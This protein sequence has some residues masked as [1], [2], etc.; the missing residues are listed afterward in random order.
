MIDDA[1]VV[2][3]LSPS[4]SPEAPPTVEPLPG[5]EGGPAPPVQPTPLPEEEKKPEPE[6]SP[7]QAYTQR[8]TRILPRDGGPGFSIHPLPIVDGVQTLV[9]KG[10]VNIV[11]NAPAPTGTIDISAD[12]AIIWRRSAATRR[13]AAPT[14]STSSPP[15]SRWKSTSKG[16][17]LSARTS[18]QCAGNGDQKTF[19]AKQ[20]YY[21]FRTGPVRRARRRDRHVRAGP[22]RPDADSSPRI[23]QFRPLVHGPDGKLRYRAEQIQRRPAR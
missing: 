5:P 22:D 7:I 23:D 1:P 10:G 4:P 3:N 8:I 15:G 14:A 19:R 21:D 17:S 13:S 9:V 12:S 6:A 16:T 2:P 18:A 20:A 11:T